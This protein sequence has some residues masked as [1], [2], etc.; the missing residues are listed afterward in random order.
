VIQKAR[1]KPIEFIQ[2]TGEKENV[3]EILNWSDNI[4]YHYIS[5]SLL[6]ETLEGVMTAGLGDY[7][8]KGVNGEFYPRKLDIFVKTYDLVTIFATLKEED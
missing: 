2:F 8:I 3:T 5:D 6:I 1:K 4:H 7:I